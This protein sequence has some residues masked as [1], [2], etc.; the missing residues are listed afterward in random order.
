MDSLTSLS[1]VSENLFL[2]VFILSL[3]FLGVCIYAYFFDAVRNQTSNEKRSA[4][5]HQKK[6]KSSSKEYVLSESALHFEQ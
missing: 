5:V 6:I 2:F 3:V 4:G 1:E